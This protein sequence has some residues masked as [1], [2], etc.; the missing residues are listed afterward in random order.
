MTWLNTSISVIYTAAQKA[1]QKTMLT[2]LVSLEAIA[3]ENSRKLSAITAQRGVQ[4]KTPFTMPI[5]TIAELE[6]ANSWLREGDN[7]TNFVSH[8]IIVG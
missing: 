5:A 7:I 8:L 2:R 3:N 1:F 4:V 6:K